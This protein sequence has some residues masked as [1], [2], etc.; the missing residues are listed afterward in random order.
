MSESS[1]LWN[2]D[3]TNEGGGGGGGRK[4]FRV[5]FIRALNAEGDVCCEGVVRIGFTV[6]GELSSV[7]DVTARP[8]SPDEEWRTG[9]VC[10]L[11]NDA[12]GIRGGGIGAD[13]EES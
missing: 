3:L 12:T 5:T 6:Q 9:Y 7:P 8:S 13:T 1:L 10:L 4:E 11:Q 2:D